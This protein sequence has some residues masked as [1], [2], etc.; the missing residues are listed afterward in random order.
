MTACRSQ[1]APPLPREIR[2]SLFVTV[3]PDGSALVLLGEQTVTCPD[4]RRAAAM[5]IVRGTR[6]RCVDCDG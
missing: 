6:Y 2:E 5:V 3:R 1:A 4:C